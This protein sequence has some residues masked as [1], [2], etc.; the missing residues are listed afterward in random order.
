MLIHCTK[1]ACEHLK[2]TPSA[3]T[4]EYNPLYSWRLNI[5]EK[6]RQRLVVFMNEASHY[7]VMLCDIKAKH[8]SKLPQ[9]FTER[10]REVMLAEQINP[11]IIDRYFAEA[12]E[13]EYFRNSNQQMTAWLN[14]ACDYVW[15]GYR[16]RDTDIDISLFA[17][18]I[19]VGTK[20]EKDYWKPSERFHSYLSKYGL[21]LKRC[22]AFELD[23][24]LQT[25]AGIVQRT[26]LVPAEITF[27]QLAKVIKRAYG[28]WSYENQYH[29]LLYAD[30]GS[31]ELYL[32]EERDSSTFNLPVFVMT[33]LRLSEYLPKYKAFRFLYDYTA[34]W[35]LGVNLTG[36]HNDYIG[37]I[38]CLKSGK[39]NAPPEYVGGADG[40]A[41]F[42]DKLE[43]GKY[44]ERQEKARW[45]KH[46][47]YEEFNL[48]KIN[49][50]I[51]NSLTK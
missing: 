51:E 9:I 45:G 42:L 49:H 13:I 6:G 35:T 8:F 37:P 11:D 33:G 23:I 46:Y 47:G 10:L 25:H 32:R 24:T 38:P 28:W 2:I 41:E 7:C 1:R 34:D 22:R 15:L 27:D 36:D 26:L 4:K 17:C 16:K 43:N 31:P 29:F 18:D 21:P 30:D 20:D 50:E 5:A 39:G 14:K 19:H 3:V 12:G 40:Y 48:E 44:A